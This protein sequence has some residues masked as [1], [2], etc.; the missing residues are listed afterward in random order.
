MPKYLLARDAARAIRSMPAGAPPSRLR[1]W[2]RPGRRERTTP[3]VDATASVR[4]ASLLRSSSALHQLFSLQAAWPLSTGQLE[5]LAAAMNRNRSAIASRKD[6]SAARRRNQ[7]S[8]SPSLSATTVH[9][10]QR[11]A[12]R[13]PPPRTNSSIARHLRA[14]AQLD[15]CSSGPAPAGWPP[16]LTH[17]TLLDAPI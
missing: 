11:S 10:R 14:L 17:A 1:H 3:I 6:R 16:F 15:G 4:S 13:G 5:R 2:N 9:A 8:A 7:R 12:G